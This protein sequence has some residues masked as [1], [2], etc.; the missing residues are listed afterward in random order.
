L[1][2]YKYWI[3][4]GVS[5]FFADMY[6]P[7]LVCDKKYNNPSDNETLKYWKEFIKILKDYKFIE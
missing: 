3:G 6:M 1:G 2:Y 7:F 5:E 4:G